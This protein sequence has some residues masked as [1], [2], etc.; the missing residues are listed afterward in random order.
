MVTPMGMDGYLLRG[1]AAA[2]HSS[3][4]QIRENINAY[5]DVVTLLDDTLLSCVASDW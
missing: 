5:A 3:K 1:C 4:M 2:A